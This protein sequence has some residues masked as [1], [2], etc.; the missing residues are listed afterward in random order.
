MSPSKNLFSSR[1][2]INKLTQIRKETRAEYFSTT[3]KGLNWLI[4][5]CT[6]ELHTLNYKYAFQIA[7][8]YE[9]QYLIKVIESN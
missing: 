3:I 2:I 1:I 8:C 9:I 5:L 6:T 4:V 7:Y